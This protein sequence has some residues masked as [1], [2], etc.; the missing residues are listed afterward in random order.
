[1]VL[2]VAISLSVLT[3]FAARPLT[4]PTPALAAGATASQ[5]R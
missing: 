2:L 5:P 1:M 3:G 4:R